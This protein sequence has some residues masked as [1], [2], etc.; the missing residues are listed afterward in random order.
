MNFGEIIINLCVAIVS[1]VVSATITK[2]FVEEKLNYKNKLRDSYKFFLELEMEI[3]NNR[4]ET[5]Y[6]FLIDCRVLYKKD[7]KLMKAFHSVD[8]SLTYALNLKKNGG[9]IVFSIDEKYLK[10]KNILEE[11]IK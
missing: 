10:F 8:I 2:F 11:R 9:S 7:K 6:Q 1:C 5:I 3:P 4:L